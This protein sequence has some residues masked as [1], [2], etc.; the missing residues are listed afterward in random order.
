[1][2][3]RGAWV[4]IAAGLGAVAYATA[5][6]RVI[7]PFAI[8]GVLL[9]ADGI[10]VLR[11]PVSAGVVPLTIALVLI[12]WSLWSGLVPGVGF[13]QAGAVIGIGCQVV[14]SYWR[15]TKGDLADAPALPPG[16]EEVKEEQLEDLVED[17]RTST[18]AGDPD[19]VEF[20]TADLFHRLVWDGRFRQADVV[21]C[22]ND[23]TRPFGTGFA[24]AATSVIVARAD[25][26]IVVKRRVL[27]GR[28][29]KARFH[30]G[31]RA[32]NGTISGEALDRYSR[33]KQSV[34]SSV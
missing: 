25:F 14:S 20:T 18:M 15:V 21:L 4:G 23:G 34:G 32:L 11:A 33:W 1:L 31:D 19:H 12:G 8:G 10:W 7:V 2:I 3:R 22:S 16:A 13:W 24:S 27:L 30:I 29:L 28:S 5:A 26:E 9:A 17:I 6:E